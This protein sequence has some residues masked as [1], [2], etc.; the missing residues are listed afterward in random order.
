MCCIELTIIELVLLALMVYEK[1]KLKPTIL[2]HQTYFKLDPK[3]FD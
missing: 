2:R 1:I 3:Q